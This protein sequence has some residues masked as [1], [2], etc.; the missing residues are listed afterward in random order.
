MPSADDEPWYKRILSLMHGQPGPTHEE[1]T[2]I[3][4]RKKIQH[5][6]IFKGK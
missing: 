6:N 3:F 1:A 2:P 5:N 4:R